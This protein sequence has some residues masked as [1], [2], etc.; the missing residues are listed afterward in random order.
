[1]GIVE[2]FNRSLRL[3]LSKLWARKEKLHLPKP[4]LQQALDE[5]TVTHNEKPAWGIMQMGLNSNGRLARTPMDLTVKNIEPEI[6]ERKKEKTEEVDDYYRDVTNR[7]EA[8]DTF[9]YFLNP[10]IEK[11][12]DS[13]FKASEHPKLSDHRGTYATD[14]HV[15]K[16]GRMRATANKEFR[17]NTFKVHGTN[18]RVLPYD[19]EF[20]KDRIVAL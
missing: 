17:T 6:M 2:R 11:N 1:L 15:I 18:R 5:I 19:V 16:P 20:V 8:G 10:A 13:F 4:T 12:K 9:R 7:L 14:R 3:Y